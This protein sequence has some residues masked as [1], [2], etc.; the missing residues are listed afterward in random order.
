MDEAADGTAHRFVLVARYLK[1]TS[2]QMSR[3]CFG[4]VN[5]SLFSEELV[6]D[7]SID[8]NEL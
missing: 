2:V 6:P 7:F 5:Q 4:L 8:C 3:S 1:T